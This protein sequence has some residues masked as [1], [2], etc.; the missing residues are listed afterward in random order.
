MIRLLPARLAP[1]LLLGAC[2]P[3]ERGAL[4]PIAGPGVAL[5]STRGLP[6]DTARLNGGGVRADVTGRW[7]NANES[8]EIA[9]TASSPAVFRIAS[10]STWRG[11]AVPASN[12]WDVST[13]E[14]GNAV[15][16]PLLGGPGLRLAAGERRTVQLVFD[17]PGGDRRPAL[18]DEVAITVP[19]PDGPV[20]VRFRLGGE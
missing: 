20:P 3:G 13:E 19:M 17:R 7:S 16:R 9:Y 15:G 11:E 18:G 1:L 10:G 2:S 14:P 12:A 6:D 4:E 8:V 5:A